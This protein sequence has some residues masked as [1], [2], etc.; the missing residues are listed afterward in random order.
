MGYGEGFDQ[1]VNGLR[2]DDAKGI[3][4]RHRDQFHRYVDV[5]SVRTWGEI[6]EFLNGPLGESGWLFRG[7][8]DRC[9]FGSYCRLDTSLERAVLRYR[10]VEGELQPIPSYICSHP[11]KFEKSLLQKF[12][13]RAHHYISNLPP[14][15][16]VLEWLALM[17]HHGVPTR[18]MDWTLSPYVALYFALEGC[19][20]QGTCALWAIDANW[21]I[22][23]S[24]VHDSNLPGAKDDKA[25]SRYI[26][27]VLLSESNAST[28]SL[29]LPTRMNE[30]SASQQGV[31]L[32]DLGS[33]GTFE[34]T[35]LNMLASDLV[36]PRTTRK[37]DEFSMESQAG[38]VDLAKPPV[39]KII[40]EFPVSVRKAGRSAFFLS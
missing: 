5:Q 12:Q 39:C 6:Q 31:F 17:Q 27:Q 14:E 18:L 13:Q 15:G 9:A 28:I 25:A 10:K 35:L 40:R 32:L 38:D 24:R 34:L 20:S 4:V 16:E 11:N 30:R 37:D 8:P 29:A 3:D 7:Q 36:N 22:V 23:Q 19:K 26:N 33:S 2:S 21:L 1:K